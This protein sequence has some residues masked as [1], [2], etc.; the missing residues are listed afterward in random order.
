MGCAVEKTATGVEIDVHVFD[1][2]D[3]AVHYVTRSRRFAF[4]RHEPWGFTPGYDFFNGAFPGERASV[5]Q[6]P[7]ANGRPT[8][9]AA[10]WIEGDAKVTEAPAVDG[11]PTWFGYYRAEREWRI[12]KNGARNPISYASVEAAYAG[13][14]FIARNRHAEE[15]RVA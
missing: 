10:F 14:M 6:G 15:P 4:E 3:D 5:R 8:W 1:T 2:K 11:K 12:V 9:I 7:Q 13:A